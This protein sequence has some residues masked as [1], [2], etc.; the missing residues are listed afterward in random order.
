MPGGDGRTVM[1]GAEPMVQI[2]FRLPREEREGLERIARV[3]NNPL[4]YVLRQAI[5]EYMAREKARGTL[6]G[7]LEGP[8]NGR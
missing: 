1:K 2:L 7:I 5:A 8:H 4:S 3:S 6:A